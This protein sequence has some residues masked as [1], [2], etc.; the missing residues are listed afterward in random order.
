MRARTVRPNAH[1]PRAAARKIFLSRDT[2][3]VAVEVSIASCA[4]SQT[5]RFASRGPSADLLRLVAQLPAQDLAEIGL[6][7]L[8]PEL[9]QPRDLVGRE[10]RLAVGD[11]GR[12]SE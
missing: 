6:R 5:P 1:K 3:R 10:P 4:S 9:H 8:G 2:A 11:Q 7:Q 12:F